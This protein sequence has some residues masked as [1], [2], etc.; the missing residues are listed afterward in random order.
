MGHFWPPGSGYGFTIRGYG[1][2]DLSESE[3]GSRIRNTVGNI[4]ST[5]QAGLDPTI[6]RSEVWC[7][8]P[9]GHRAN[10]AINRGRSSSWCEGSRPRWPRRRR[11][12]QPRQSSPAASVVANS[13]QKNFRQNGA[14]IRPLSKKCRSLCKNSIFKSISSVQKIFR[15]NGP[16]IRPL[17]KKIRSL[18]KKQHLW[19]HFIK[20]R[21]NFWKTYQ[22][23]NL[24]KFYIFYVSYGKNT[25]ETKCFKY[26]VPFRPFMG[27][28]ICTAAYNYFFLYYYFLQI[29]SALFELCG[30]RI[31]E[32]GMG[33]LPAAPRQW[34]S[35][36]APPL[37]ATHNTVI[38]S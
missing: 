17:S 29:Y 16:K 1:S 2:T 22:Y 6:P 18:V 11:P 33:T 4:K 15:Q 3:S 23:Q 36:P 13:F 35:R 34:G 38:K 27:K 8:S 21:Q 32:L 37:H 31:G 26:L 20:I 5:T 25:Q 30:R 12:G 7:L 28:Q 9:L 14:K 24:W 19:F 10:S